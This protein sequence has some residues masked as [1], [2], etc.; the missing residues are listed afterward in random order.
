[1]AKNLDAAV[2]KAG[3]QQKWVIVYYTRSSCPPCN[4]VQGQM[5]RDEI[6]SGFADDFIFTVI[7]S[8]GMNTT[9]REKYRSRYGVMGAPTWLVYNERKEY[10]CTASGGFGTFEAGLELANT[11]KKLN[12]SGT[13]KEAAAAVP[14]SRV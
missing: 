13:A 11:V 5:K 14:G 10:I 7:W 3:E 4:H 9:D 8:N 6:R 2:A 1:M 12:A